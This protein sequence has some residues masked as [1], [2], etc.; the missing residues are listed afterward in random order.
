VLTTRLRANGAGAYDMTEN[1]AKRGFD[2]APPKA[3]A[4]AWPDEATSAEARVSLVDVVQFVLLA[5]AIILANVVIVSA[6]DVAL[7]ALFS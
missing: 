2:A 5:G 6:L 1:I 3:D 7:D 4:S